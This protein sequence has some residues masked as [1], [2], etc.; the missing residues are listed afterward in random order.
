MALL[1]V[2]D[3]DVAVRRLLVTILKSRGH[4]VV[5]AGDGA[6]ALAQV[7]HLHPAVILSDILMPTMDGYEFT[8]LLREDAA[9]ADISVIFLTAEY[10]ERAGNDLARSIGVASVLSKP[11]DPRVILDAV[12]RVLAA[13]SKPQAIAT[14]GSFN[15]RHLRVM[16]DKLSEQAE[17]LR[18][19]NA[20][21]A[22]LCQLNLRLASE[23][24]V[25]AMCDQACRGAR[26]LFGAKYAAISVQLAA[27]TEQATTRFAGLTPEQAVGFHQ[28]ARVGTPFEQA[29]RERR[30]VRIDNPHGDPR[31]FGLSS[32]EPR[33][34]SALVAPVVFQARVYGWLCVID[35]ID[36]RDFDADDER[37]LMMLGAQVGSN[38][39]ISD[40][41]LR[42]EVEVRERTLAGEK[43]EHLN[44]VY[45]VLSGIN[46]LLV[47]VHDR[48][49]LF[50][51]TCRLSIEAGKFRVAWIGTCDPDA[52]T[53]TPLAWAG[54][55]S[56]MAD[57]IGVSVEL[58]TA[59]GRSLVSEAVET[60][61][62]VVCNDVEAAA[63]GIRF[64]DR[65]VAEGHRSITVLP[66]VVAEQVIGILFL[67][68]AEHAFFDTEE[69]RLLSELAADVSFALDNIQK[70]QQLDYLSYYDVLTNLANGTLLRQR[71]AQNISDT[72]RG[73]HRLA[74][75]ITDIDRLE[76]INDTFGR[77]VGDQ[78]LRTVAQRLSQCVGDVNRIARVGADEFAVVIPDARSESEVARQVNAWGRQLFAEPIRAEADE[79]GISGKAGIA[80]FPDDARDPE[81]LLACA[82]AALKK[83]KSTT[84]S[85]L[86]Y[87][88]DMSE[89]TAE[90]LALEVKVRRGLENEEFVLYYQPKVDA[91]T[92][93]IVGVEAL[94][95]W[96]SPELGLLPP[97]KF[98]P[99][100]EETGM[101][102]DAGRWA[103]HRA[104][105]DR[106][107]W[108]GQQFPAP[109]IAINVSTIELRRR[110]FVRSFANELRLAG[111]DAGIDIEVTESLIMEDVDSNIGKL[112][113]IRAMG[114]EIGID[115]FG[116]G[117]SSL[118]YL[119]RLPV[120]VL[121]IDRSFIANMLQDTGTMTLVSTMI[122][123][124]KSL[125]LTV[126][127]E[128][129]ESEEQAKML[130]LLHCD[131]L[132]GYL[133]CRPL[134][135]EDMTARLAS[136][137]TSAASRMS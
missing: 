115:D 37:V 73:S 93:S 77:G 12:D 133:F 99:V 60:R 8:R 91:V 70:T 120:T 112:A 54:T 116:T 79:F 59:H 103:L 61:H 13:G 113:Q 24:E 35:K 58:H 87:T 97:S 52:K 15:V 72:E 42:L 130:R 21:L 121:K 94:M 82:R 101:I 83:S 57:A 84:D 14:T 92:G 36:A 11:C 22:E 71:L 55:D 45:A 41:A 125:R 126:I 76:M 80:V 28:V 95:R 68:A 69:M 30:A 131:Q 18:A 109:R 16:T 122:S 123:L 85:F 40:N 124:G 10:H 19:A 25:E 33:M 23:H 132:Q 66:L 9:N 64:G 129:V 7:R 27:Q 29:L 88:Q 32:A 105:I 134:S 48:D 44:R 49:Q 31:D 46:A 3:D 38:L 117:Y 90:R 53:I 67:S 104:I 106:S 43:I 39:E 20:R 98:I 102:V 96:N 81:S 17:K 110:D 74:L 89:R 108:L 118:A 65:F 135:F 107:R 2:V 119:A 78:V 51:E 50:A 5:E 1:M 128:G 127:A 75:V 136:G 62:P 4:R 26:E 63:A 56:Q 111:M 34:R 114:V 86:F 137:R 6:E 47:R 100:M